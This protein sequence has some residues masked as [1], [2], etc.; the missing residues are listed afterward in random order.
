MNREAPGAPPGAFPGV[1]EPTAG[2]D[3]LHGLFA[4]ATVGS[5]STLL[6]FEWEVNFTLDTLES[7]GHG[8]LWKYPVAVRQGWTARVKGYFTRAGV[9][10]ATYIATGGKQ[11]ADPVAVTFT[12]YS[13]PGATTAI[14]IGDGLITRANFS[15]PMAMVTQ[16]IEITGVGPATTGPTA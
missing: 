9:A 4:L 13:T 2:T 15:A 5:V 16:E 10:S 14:F 6:C 11:S 1:G 12:G 8:D 7:A 3:R